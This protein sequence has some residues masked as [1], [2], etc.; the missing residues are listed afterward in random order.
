VERFQG[1]WKDEKRKMDEEMKMMKKEMESML[2]EKRAVRVA[3]E[4][5]TVRQKQSVS[6]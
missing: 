2:E 3:S 4:G 1:K 5:A 6:M